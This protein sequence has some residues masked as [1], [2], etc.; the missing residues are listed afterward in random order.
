M[1]SIR[2]AALLLAAAGC[3]CSEPS[4]PVQ[5]KSAAGPSV[6]ISMVTS[7]Q[8][9]QWLEIAL[10]RFRV[11]RPDI[12]VLMRFAGSNEEIDAILGG[13]E[14]PTIFS[15]NEAALLAELSSRARTERGQEILAS[16][17]D[18]A[19]RSVLKTPY[20]F[21]G[22]E[23]VV[24]PLASGS[25]TLTWASVLAEV[26]R[27]QAAHLPP[28]RYGYVDL[29]RGSSGLNTILLV[30]VERFGASGPT[31][32]QLQQPAFAKSL[33][34]LNAAAT[35]RAATTSALA[36]RMSQLG[37]DALDLVFTYESTAIELART[38]G[39]RGEKPM[40]IYYPEIT[41]ASD[42]PAAVLQA[43]WVSPAQREAAHAWLD[44]LQGA[45]MQTEASR[46]GLR[47]NDAA[48]MD[49]E[50]GPFALVKRYGFRRHLP[51][52]ASRPDE[53]VTRVLVG[54]SQRL[55][56]PAKVAGR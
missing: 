13:R 11:E 10:A 53:A 54:L 8:K 34:E 38:L 35:L 48:L 29:S 42:Q 55:G 23:K 25:G 19:P 32:Q 37:P 51:P 17:G 47:P 26:Q 3:A 46:L 5:K 39:D 9:R 43:E 31:V 52:A 20:V 15:P 40:R 33:D 4:G 6:E 24:G 36:A 41:V 14:K 28:L 21:L 18:D 7:T 12:R 2:K 44:F 49:M 27:R 1:S 56:G 22:N 16:R 50:T 30:A 45:A